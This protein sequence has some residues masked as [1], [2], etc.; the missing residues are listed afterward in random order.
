MGEFMSTPP[1]LRSPFVVLVV[2]IA[3]AACGGAPGANPA[4]NPGALARV[5]HS[6]SHMYITFHNK[7]DAYT[8][9]TRYWSYLIDP[10]WHIEGA[11]CIG[12][13][14]RYEGDIVYHLGGPQ[15]RLRVETK[16]KADCTGPTL[17]GGDV[18]GP[19]CR[20]NDQ[21]SKGNTRDAYADVDL[22]GSLGQFDLSRFKTIPGHVV[23]CQFQD[24][25]P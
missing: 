12:P 6:T 17:R 8:L 7:V 23:P 10:Q 25:K 20:V 19:K 5:P 16:S 14:Q 18:T 24:P 21:D 3:L 15:A 13:G 22:T 9:L 1:H 11:N 2:A 4:P